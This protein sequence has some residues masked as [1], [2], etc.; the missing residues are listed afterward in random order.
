MRNVTES[1][2]GRINLIDL[3]GLSLREIQGDDFR[4]SFLPTNKYYQ[5]REAQPPQVIKYLDI[6][7]HIWRGF[8]PEIVESNSDW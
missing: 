2:A 7:K 6:W 1:L 3:Y 5:K 4:E 8:F